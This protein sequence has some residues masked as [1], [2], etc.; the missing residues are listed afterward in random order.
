MLIVDFPP[1]LSFLL[2]YM[3]IITS[4]PILTSPSPWSIPADQLFQALRSC[5][6]HSWFPKHTCVFHALR[7]LP[8]FLLLYIHAQ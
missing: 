6:L 4:L 8:F 5:A 7:L 1:A 3:S 2:A